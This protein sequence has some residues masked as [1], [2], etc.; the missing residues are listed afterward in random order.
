MNNFLILL[1][2]IFPVI[3]VVYLKLKFVFMIFIWQFHFRQDF[4]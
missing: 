3:F 4:P 1:Y 2:L